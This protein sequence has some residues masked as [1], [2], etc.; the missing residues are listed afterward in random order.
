MA[1][2][3]FTRRERDCTSH[4]ISSCQGSYPARHP[5]ARYADFGE[6]GRTFSPVVATLIA[7][8]GTGFDGLTVH[9]RGTGFG[10]PPNSHAQCSS[11]SSIDLLPNASPFPL[12]EIQVDRTPVG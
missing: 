12:T 5:S 2:S 8:Y 9:N 6:T 3:A 4:R 11:Q 10:F 1:I 7:T